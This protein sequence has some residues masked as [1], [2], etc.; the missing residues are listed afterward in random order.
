M[1]Y[2]NATPMPAP[3][4]SAF[5]FK[6]R[7]TS[8]ERAAIRTASASNA[9]LYDYMDMLNTAGY[10]NLLDPYTI[11]GCQSLETAGLIAA[12][13]SAQILSLVIDPSEYYKG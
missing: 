12:G 10:A 5:A 6:N 9:T 3:V 8:D 2:I 4:I 11:G 13:R 1:D 7:M